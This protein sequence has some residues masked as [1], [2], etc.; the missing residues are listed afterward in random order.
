MVV[1]TRVIGRV[2]VLAVITAAVVLFLSDPD[3]A[4]LVRRSGSPSTPE[5]RRPV[6]STTPGP[7]LTIGELDG[8]GYNPQVTTQPTTGKPQSKLWHHDGSWW[9]ILYRS[10]GAAAIFRLDWASQSW[11]D[12]GTV[13]D[14]RPSAR[15]DALIEGNQLYV[16]SAGW[17][18][19]PSQAARLLRYTYDPATEIFVPDADFPVQLSAAGVHSTTIARDSVGRLWVALVVGG[20]LLITHSTN[21]DHRWV[22]PTPIGVGVDIREVEEASIFAFDRQIGV[23]WT[24]ANEDTVVVARRHDSAPLD[25]WDETRTVVDGL[26]LADDH[27]NVKVARIDGATRVFVVIKTSLNDLR[28]RNPRHPQIL[29][30]ELLDDGSWRQHLVGRVE[31]N[32]T[33]PILAIDEERGRIFVVATARDGIYLKESALDPI[34]F[35]EGV[36]TPFII[37]AGRPNDA[38]TTKQ[39]VNSDTGLV[40]ASSDDMAGIYRTG[41]VDLGGT[42]IPETPASP[43]PPATPAKR[44]VTAHDFDPLQ[45]GSVPVGWEG[46]SEADAVAAQVAEVPD[47]G[48]GLVVRSEDGAHRYCGAFA[49]QSSGVVELV[50]DVMVG[51]EIG[52]GASLGGLRGIGAD[53]GSVRMA[54]AGRLFYETGGQRVETP[55]FLAPG[56]WYR[57]VISADIES[58][59]YSWSIARRG[60]ETPLLVVD[61][62]SWQLA[63]PSLNR[64]CFATPDSRA[65]LSIDSVR[66]TV[67]H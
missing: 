60:A 55:V 51:P 24:G 8:P 56:V 4:G 15:S 53:T 45:L 23:I 32:H 14:E 36:G 26:A 65:S 44:L 48:I 62:L 42:P 57:V 5:A 67:E 38:T 19:H 7:A 27:L 46:A 22:E 20:E 12:T 17:N 30:L 6:T 66:V 63:G 35:T 13:V 52:G 50:A 11:Q 54:S 59:T 34:A 1:L 39:N 25:A 41:V 29:L 33:R 37:G 58:A 3:A 61:G 28:N 31:N 9:S 10:D 2:A 64:A 21:S 40:V 43:P 16:V 47:G 18:R 49:T